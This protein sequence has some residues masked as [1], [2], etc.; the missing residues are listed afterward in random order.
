MG[1]A[2][3]LRQMDE[4]DTISS[5]LI[6]AKVGDPAAIDRVFPLIYDELRRLAR[7]HLRREVTGHTLSTTDLVHQAYVQLVG[8]TSVRWEGRSHFF[9]IAA[10][11]MRRILVDH[12][13][14]H[15]SLKRG[16]M[17]RRVPLESVDLAMEDRADLLL[18]LDEALDRLRVL[19][20]RQ[21]QVVEYRFFAGMTEEETAEALGVNERTARRDWAKARSWLYQELYRD[22]AP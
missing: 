1:I 6:D 16:G 10:T 4:R 14:S 5:L 13:R 2:G 15:G 8:Q 20:A 12:A 17:L 21:A 3:G 22:E 11:A 19:D 7:Q 18:A 9:A